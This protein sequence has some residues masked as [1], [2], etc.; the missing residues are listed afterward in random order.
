MSGARRDCENSPTTR[1]PAVI[2][3][4]RSSD[5]RIAMSSSPPASDSE[6]TKAR[7]SV[8]VL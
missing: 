3:S 5:S 2:A 8:A 1:A 6:T 4:S 7:S